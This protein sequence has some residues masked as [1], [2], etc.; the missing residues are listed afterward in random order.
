[1]PEQIQQVLVGPKGLH[2]A[3]FQVMLTSPHQLLRVLQRPHFGTDMA[4]FSE[5][6][7]IVSSY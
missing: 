7:L 6:S 1:M 4:G 2:L 3:E 5:C